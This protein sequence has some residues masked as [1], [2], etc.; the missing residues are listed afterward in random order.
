[1]EDHSKLVL[2]QDVMSK[3]EINAFTE[4]MVNVDWIRGVPGG[5]IS[6]TP[7][8]DVLSFGNGSGYDERA[9]SIGAGWS[10]GFWPPAVHQS[11]AT[12]ATPTETLPL[13]LRDMGVLARKLASKLYGSALQLNDHTF[14]LAVCNRYVNGGDNIAAHTDDNEWYQRDIGHSPLFASITLYPRAI[15]GTDDQHANFQLFDDK[16]KVW[17]TRVLP[18]ASILFMPACI[19]H[20]VKAS[21]SASAFPRINVTFRSVPSVETD[22]LRSLMG[23]SNHARYYRLPSEL[24]LA[25]D[26]RD[27]THVKFAQKEFDKILRQ[28]ERARLSVRQDETTAQRSEAKKTIKKTLQKNKLLT[29]PLRGNMVLEVLRQVEESAKIANRLC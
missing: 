14:N 4:R 3:E 16:D 29:M 10:T 5:F 7:Q 22:P 26:K 12:L 2:L 11:D 23:V 25:T 19:R 15:P 18:H 28:Y 6:N 9:E 1:M 20:R 13:F 24:I 8:R 17:R 27:L 21:K